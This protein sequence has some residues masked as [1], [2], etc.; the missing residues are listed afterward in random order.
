MLRACRT[1]LSEAGETYA[2]H[3]RFALTVGAL[4]IGAGLACIVHAFVPGVCGTS[5]SRTIA[6]L[7]RLFADRNRLAEVAEQSS[8][9][10]VFVGLVAISSTTA[11]ITA[12]AGAGE[13]VTCLAALQALAFPLLYVAQNPGLDPV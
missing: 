13:P 6:Q 11:L 2:E 12:L 5:C 8:G 10:T 9:V 3:M 4:A 1:H 7:Q